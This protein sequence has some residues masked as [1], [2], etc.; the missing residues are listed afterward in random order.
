MDLEVPSGQAVRSAPAS[1]TGPTVP[2]LPAAR[3]LAP[4]DHPWCVI[5]ALDRVSPRAIVLIE[6][7]LWPVAIR[8]ASCR[9]IPVGVASASISERSFRRYRRLGRFARASFARLAFVAARG[10]R[11][12]ERFV[13]LGARAE[14]V[15]T[16]GDLKLD[17]ARA[18]APLPD[19]VVAALPDAPLLV[20]GST[21][22][23]EEQAL[24]AA[25][26]RCRAAGVEMRLA[27]APRRSD[28]AAAVAR[29]VARA[30][31]RERR[32]SA[33]HRAPLDADEVVII[34]VPGELPGWYRAGAVAFVGGTLVPVGGHNLYEPAAA[35]AL[36]LH[37]PET[38][39]VAA[40]ERLL[41]DARA[42]ERVGDEAALGVA[43]VRWMARPD[44]AREA[45]GRGAWAVAE[46]S[47]SAGRTLAWIDETIARGPR[48]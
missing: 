7:E 13:A 26:A 38:A 20:A 30:G 28:R 5:R 21:H 34:D 41:A 42:S 46:Q 11:D 47:G 39:S 31:L 18:V 3:A 4:L 16:T 25:L 45:G 10:E 22:D 36:V 1:S 29:A 23:G 12:A 14:R 48:R 6:T 15:R 27:I 35:G 40:A 19:E 8:E 2:A 9:G 43:V 17:V 24:L 32:R 37:G 33:W 44:A